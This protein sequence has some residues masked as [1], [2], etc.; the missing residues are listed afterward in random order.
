MMDVLVAARSDSIYKW[1]LAS[2]KDDSYGQQKKAPAPH[3]SFRTLSIGSVNN[4][5]PS[6]V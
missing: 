5:R 2:G 4:G 6:T 3:S 1:R